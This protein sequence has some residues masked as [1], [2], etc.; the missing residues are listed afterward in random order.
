[1]RAAARQNGYG[2]L[3]DSGV[4]KALQGLT[5]AEEVIGVAGTGKD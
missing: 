4:N 1:M 3:L 5:T 2:S